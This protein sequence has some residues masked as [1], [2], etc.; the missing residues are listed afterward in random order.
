M[1]YV[2]AS[3]L[4]GGSELVTEQ[5]FLEGTEKSE[6]EKQEEA[7][8]EAQGSKKQVVPGIAYMGHIPRASDPY[9]QALQGLRG[10]QMHVLSG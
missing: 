8:E 10:G 9:T 1:L 4:A 3:M 2:L 7:K 5:E 6:V